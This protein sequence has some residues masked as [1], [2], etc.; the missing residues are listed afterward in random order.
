MPAA[1]HPDWNLMRMFVT[2]AETGSL[3]AAAKSLDVSHATAAR[4][5]QQLEEAVGVSLFDRRARGLRLNAA[6]ASLADAARRMLDAANEF[7]DRSALISGSTTG[8]V[9]VSTSDYLAD[10]LPEL[11]D[12]LL[13]NDLNDSYQLELVVTNQIVNLLEGEADI[14]LRHGEPRQQDLMCRRL[15]GLP[16]GVYASDA[17]IDRHGLPTLKAIHEHWFIEGIT[18][19]W[20]ARGAERLGIKLRD[21]QFVFRSDSFVGQLHAARAGWGIVGLPRHIA[22]QHP[23]LRRVLTHADIAQLDLWLVG[24]PEVRTTGYLRQA[25]RVIGDAVN[26]FFAPPNVAREHVAG[27]SVAPEPHLRG[28]PARSIGGR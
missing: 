23:F 16:F 18:E 26:A 4:H 17:Y 20:I 22:I 8:P 9:R 15:H 10:V 12:P 14:A 25:F 6:G 1:N 7:A 3:A 5:V 21:Q 13:G 28:A 24:R 2:V 11:L 19:H 27:E